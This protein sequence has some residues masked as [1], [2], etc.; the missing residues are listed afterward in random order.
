MWGFDVPPFLFGRLHCCRPNYKHIR[1]VH[2]YTNTP[3]PDPQELSTLALEHRVDEFEQNDKNTSVIILNR[4]KEDLNENVSE[5]IMKFSAESLNF[6]LKLDDI[7][8]SNR[9]GGGGKGINRVST[10]LG[11]SF[12]HSYTRP[13]L[14][15]FKSLQTKNAFKKARTVLK[16][17]AAVQGIFVND[18]LTR[19]RRNMLNSLIQLKKEKIITDCWSYNGRI[20]YKTRQGLIVNALSKPPVP[21]DESMSN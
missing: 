10:N 11:S 15:K 17:D 2:T 20:M 21:D 4:W 19:I 6:P 18:D 14:V 3:P 9:I 12:D 5:L 7:V 1:D 13:I 16:H 8:K